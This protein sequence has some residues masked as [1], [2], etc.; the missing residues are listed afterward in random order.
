MCA[1]LSPAGASG[2]AGSTPLQRYRADLE[3]EDFQH[4][5]AQER[6]VQHLQRL[7]DALLAAPRTEPRAVTTG[8][9][10]K[11]R[12]AG[13][14]GRRSR[15]VDAPV[16]PDIQGLYL[17]GGVGRGKTYLMDVFHESLPFPDKMR[18][19]FH[20]FMQRVHNE[21]SITRGKRIP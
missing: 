20:R 17:W 13:L 7:H 10:L 18:T 5:P 6:A 9:G 21:L 11:S 1:T 8:R 12:M 16:L 3:R 2:G 19:H 14:L 15:P 4:D